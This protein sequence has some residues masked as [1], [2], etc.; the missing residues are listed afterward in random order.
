MIHQLF[1][2]GNCLAQADT[3]QDCPR[4]LLI[5]KSQ[6][7][8]TQKISFAH[9]EAHDHSAGVIPLHSQELE[10]YTILFFYKTL[11]QFY[12]W[13]KITS[14]CGFKALYITRSN[15]SVFFK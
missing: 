9:Q 13:I 3:I 7:P 15:V 6:H 1:Q 2:A 10:Q 12:Q 5:K 4:I 8:I 14:I 11:D